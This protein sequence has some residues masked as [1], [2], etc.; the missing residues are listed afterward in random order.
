MVDPELGI[1][2]G[3]CPVCGNLPRFSSINAEDATR[4]LVCGMCETSW[5]YRRIGC[6][7]CG[8]DDASTYGYYPGDDEAYRLY[9]CKNCSHYLKVLD[10]RKV[11][12]DR[13]LM[14][15]RLGTL[16][17]DIAALQAGYTGV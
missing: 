11:N 13:I 2:S 9:A 10:L 17:M 14:V 3:A 5:R 4:T 7:F 12:D 15:E 1:L 8:N 6:P 16:P